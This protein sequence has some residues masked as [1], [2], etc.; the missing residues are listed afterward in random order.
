MSA[1]WGR[2]FHTDPFALLDRGVDELDLA[3][4]IYQAAIKDLKAERG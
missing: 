2:L 1:R 3:V 4:A